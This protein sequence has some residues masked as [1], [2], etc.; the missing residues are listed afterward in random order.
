MTGNM[1][2]LKGS[3]WVYRLCL[4]AGLRA[5]PVLDYVC[6]SVREVNS[7]RHADALLVRGE[8]A[9][10]ETARRLV[11]TYRAMPDPKVVFLL[12]A[13]GAREA[14]EKCDSGAKVFDLD[15]GL[16]GGREIVEAMV[17]AT[18]AL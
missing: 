8:C 14:I 11:S 6:A 18:E 9:G 1:K 2:A 16:E 10:T 15:A 7:P 3:C 5:A 12:G 13:E 4:E 17:R